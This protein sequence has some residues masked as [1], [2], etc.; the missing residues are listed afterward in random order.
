[1]SSRVGS[2]V[3]RSRE[4]RSGSASRLVWLAHRLRAM[5]AEEVGFRIRRKLELRAELS[6]FR[7]ARPPAASGRSGTPWLAPLPRRFEHGRYTDAADRILAGRFRIFA[8]HDVQL[9]FPPRWNVDPLTGIEAP[10]V[11]GKSIDYRDRRLAGDAKSL[12]ELNRHLELVTLAEAWHLC[13]DPRYAKGARALL[14][15]WIAECP[16]PLGLNWCVSLEPAVRLINWMFAWHLLGAEASI[17]FR[18]PSGRS[19]RERWLRSVYQHCH[20]IAGYGSRHS[21]SN[22]HRLGE[23]VGLLVG[24]LTWPLWEESAHWRETAYGELAHETLEQTFSDGVNRE[25]AV[26]YHQSVAEM[27]LIAGL[28]ARASGRDFAPQYWQRLGAM[29]DFLASLMDASG[30]VPAFG[31]ADDGVLAGLVPRGEEQVFESLLGC[32]AVLLGRPALAAKAAGLDDK[33]R[34]LLG[35]AAEQ[36][37]AALASAGRREEPIRAYRDGGYFVLGERFGTPREVRI[38]ADAGPLG[39]LSI[40]AHGH[41]D[42]LSFTL[43]AAGVPML[44]DPGTYSYDPTGPWRRYFR[45][46]SAHNTITV[47]GEDQSIYRGGFLWDR[48]ASAHVEQFDLEGAVPTL[49]AR[50]EGYAR[51]KDPVHHRRTW[52][53][54]A[55]EGTLT[56]LDEIMCNS[57]HHLAL[58][59][60]LAPQCRVIQQG[61]VI[62]VERQG[63]RLWLEGP[64]VL[65]PQVVIGREEPPLGWFSASFGVKEPAPTVVF[66][67]V[68]SGNASLVSRLR[69][70]LDRE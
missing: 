12:W 47:D 27:T 56:V 59:W 11:F 43:S 19:F 48:H 31:D 9:G 62:F 17:L 23:A 10:S 52:R 38:V 5:S 4:P 42:A 45:G 24:A 58:H 49:V 22:N 64:A 37:F 16:Y 54:A 63:V 33:S 25:Q 46:T 68:L 66:S 13:G 35:D 69:V 14:E 26:W 28:V 30:H 53:Y 3:A 8:L 44:V 7:L 21:S 36:R 32:G 60:H 18:G 70:E 15:S 1:M 40:A 29:L 67:G 34:W 55:A 39:Y 51:L 57:A 65:Q 20:F 50:H 41:A 2:L 6:G 61:P